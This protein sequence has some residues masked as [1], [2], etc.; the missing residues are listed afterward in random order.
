MGN[1]GIDNDVTNV[2]HLDNLAPHT[3]RLGLLHHIYL[4]GYGLLTII[5]IN[6]MTLCPLPPSPCYY[7]R[8]FFSSA[9]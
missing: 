5:I 4:Q 7:S 6:M 2:T 3:S 8:L 9:L 1:G